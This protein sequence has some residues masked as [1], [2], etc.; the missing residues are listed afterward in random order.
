MGA[1]SYRLFT[2]SLSLSR[3]ELLRASDIKSPH[4]NSILSCTHT[5]ALGS[6]FRGFGLGVCGF[7]F[8]SAHTN[9]ILSWTAQTATCDA[10]SLSVSLSRS[11]SLCVSDAT[12]ETTDATCHATCHAPSFFLPLSL[13]ACQ[14]QHVRQHVMHASSLISSGIEAA[15]LDTCHARIKSHLIAHHL[16]LPQSLS[17]ARPVDKQFVRHICAC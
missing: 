6:L 9:S 5:H 11:L 7:G 3:K 16:S 1:T 10:L 15:R 13:Y 17:E 4:T 2:L 14:T 8:K 12:C